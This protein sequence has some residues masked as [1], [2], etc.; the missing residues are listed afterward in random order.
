M[1]KTV[2]AALTA[3]LMLGGCASVDTHATFVTKTAIAL[4][5]VDSAPSGISFGYERTEG[6]LGPRLKDGSA[7]PVFGFIRTNGSLLGRSLQQVYATGCAAE[8]VAEAKPAASG[9]EPSACTQVPLKDEKTR[10]MLFATSTT[11]GVGFTLGEGNVPSLTLGYRR[12][13]A[14]VIPVDPGAMPSVLAT[15]GNEVQA[16]VASAKAKSDIGVT[17]FFAT[18][19][20]ANALAANKEVVKLFRDGADSALG[21]YRQQERQQ[22]L[23][24]L[25]T[26]GCLSA[27]EDQRLP[28][29]WRNAEALGLLP[30]D[31]D[32]ASLDKVGAA[33]AR[34]TYTRY[35]VILNADSANTTTLM[36]LH[37]SFVCDLSKKA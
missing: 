21:A 35:L 14:S 11:L 13:E 8:V 17:Q 16:D 6:Y 25:S 37:R 24:A 3:A 18:G 30:A 5:D 29:V 34:E 36:D 4:V 9:S 31:I 27:L 10:P 20:A 2:P 7:V 19:R 22:S 33:K 1:N 23:H 12:K 15:H 28:A 26:L 32:A